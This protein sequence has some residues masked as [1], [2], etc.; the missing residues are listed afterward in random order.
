MSN[1]NLLDLSGKH[2]LVTGGSSGLGRAFAKALALNGANIAIIDINKETGQATAEMIKGY[3]VEA[4]FIACDVTDEAQVKAA[5]ATVAETFGRLDIAVNS[6]GVGTH[7]SEQLHLSKKDWDKVININLTGTW[8]CNQAQAQQ[9]IKQSPAGGKIIN[10]ASLAAS[11]VVSF[12]SAYDASKAGVVQLTRNLA[13][14][15]GRYNININCISP[16][17][18]LTPMT[19]ASSLADREKTRQ[20]TPMRHL[21]RPQDLYGPI[22]FLASEASN[23]ITGHN[24]VLDGGYSIFNHA[25]CDHADSD[26]PPRV[27]PEEEV[28]ELKQDLEA[29]NIP[30]DK[31]GV[32]QTNS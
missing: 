25:A 6:A 20:A 23:Y 3:G 30:Y 1:D 7:G 21:Q 16:G 14:H 18:V 5:V 24:L 13:V 28:E 26:I 4:C 32:V 17:V 8:L 10:I 22:C 31:D 29:L 19:A 12:G 15:W 9:M 2:A 27:S 11:Q